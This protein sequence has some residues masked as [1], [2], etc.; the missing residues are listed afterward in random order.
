[1]A[2]TVNLVSVE[3]KLLGS[4]PREIGIVAT[5]VTKGSSLLI[6]G[7][8]QVQLLHNVT[9]SK[10]E[11]VAHNSANICFGASVF[12]RAISVNM[13]GQRVSQADCVR[14]L[15]ESSVAKS[16]SDER[17]GNIACIVCSG[18]VYLS[19]VFA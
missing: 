3:I 4:L 10:V 15:K 5:K 14:H 6:N 17:L 11:V 18:S 9:R 13:D 16:G 1:M 12:R 19:G 2:N 7:P 8:L